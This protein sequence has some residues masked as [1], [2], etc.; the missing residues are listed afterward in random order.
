MGSSNSKLVD[1][2]WWE[3]ALIYQIWPR[4]FQDSDGNGEGDLKGIINRLD[5]LKDLGIDAIWLNP[6]YSSPLIDSGYDI[7]NYTDINPLFGNL[8][9][10]DELIREA[11]NRDLKVILDIVPNH[12]SDQHEWFL[13]SSQNIK[14][15]NDYYIWA[16]GFT[17]G[18]KK[19]PPNNWVS[20]YNDE[21]GSAWTWHDKRKQWYYHKF[22]KSQPDLNLRNE[23]VLQEL[24]NVFN[25]WLK[26]NVDGFR[27][28]AVSYFYE[29]ID[30]KNEFKGNRT[31]G[32]PENTALVYKFRSYIDDW[33][34]K[35]N[36]TSKLLIAE[37]YELK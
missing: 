1:K 35:N 27:I 15:Y 18:N 19:I 12:S 34:K 21:E 36:A 10:F 29:D 14:P 3:T 17:D 11:H 6:I 28:S 37:Y 16:N 2:Q 26:K 20:T 23:N 24:L 32:L 7:S 8:Q 9:D 31:S 4:G 13:L 25:F 22:H 30:L 5:Y 33:V